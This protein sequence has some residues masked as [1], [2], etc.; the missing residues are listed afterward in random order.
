MSVFIPSVIFVEK[1]NLTKKQKAK[2][3][4]ARITCL[5]WYSLQDPFFL[6]W[7]KQNHDE[8]IIFVLKDAVVVNTYILQLCHTHAYDMS[9]VALYE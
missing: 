6:F 3:K 7:S 1:R 5:C 9:Y 2:S 4:C 8:V